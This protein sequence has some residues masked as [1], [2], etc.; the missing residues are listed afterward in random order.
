MID[1]RTSKIYHRLLQ[2]FGQTAVRE[3]GE[4]RADSDFVRWCHATSD[5][6]VKSA[7]AICEDR[8]ASGQQFAPSLGILSQ[9]YKMLTDERFCYI[10]KVIRSGVDRNDDWRIDWILRKHAQDIRLSSQ[11]NLRKVTAMY[12]ARACETR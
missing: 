5:E 6:H 11:N 3:Y 12:Y 10:I 7:F 8:L 1:A 4:L 9:S 2:Y